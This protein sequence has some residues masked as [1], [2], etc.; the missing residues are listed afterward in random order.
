MDEEKEKEKE[1]E[2]EEEE[3]GKQIKLRSNEEYKRCRSRLVSVSSVSSSAQ[4]VPL[5]PLIRINYPRHSN[6]YRFSIQSLLI[7]G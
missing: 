5:S 4:N 3:E 2:E 1:E 7:S 6:R